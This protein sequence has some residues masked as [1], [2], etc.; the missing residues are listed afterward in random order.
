MNKEITVSE[1]EK[2]VKEFT[3]VAKKFH[4]QAIIMK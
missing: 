4:Y 2:T 1:F 3:K